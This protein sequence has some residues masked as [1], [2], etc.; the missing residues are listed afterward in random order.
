[1]K[2][3][4]RIHVDASQQFLAEANIANP[5]DYIVR[6]C[7]MRIAKEAPMEVLLNYFNVTKLDPLADNSKVEDQ[8]T[9]DLLFLLKQMNI[10]R[11]EVELK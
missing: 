6:E 4:Y 1:M 10:V 2:N 9:K 5:E 3:K 11:F 7:M 8:Y